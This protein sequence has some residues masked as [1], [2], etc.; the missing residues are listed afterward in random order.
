MVFTTDHFSVYVLT[1]ADL[2][3]PAV[4]LG[5]ING[6]GVVNTID[7]RWAL[8]AASGIRTL[9]DAQSAA[10]DVNGDGTVNTVDAR[11]ILQAASGIRVL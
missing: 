7:A 6:D 2:T 10:A 3:A 4:L 5:D 1:T 11:W 8:Q 9:S